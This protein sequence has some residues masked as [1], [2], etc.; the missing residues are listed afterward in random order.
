[1]GTDQGNGPLELLSRPLIRQPD[2]PNLWYSGSGPDKAECV[3]CNA[4]LLIGYAP[5]SCRAKKE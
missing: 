2:L 4:C 5:I 3:S 1:M